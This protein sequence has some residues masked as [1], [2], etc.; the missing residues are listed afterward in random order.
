MEREIIKKEVEN[1]LTFEEFY[2]A[3]FRGDKP[4]DETLLLLKELYGDIENQDTPIK[5]KI[6]KANRLSFVLLIKGI[7]GLLDIK[8]KVGEWD[9]E[10]DELRFTDEETGYECLIMRGIAGQLNGYVVIPKDHP[11]YG[12]DLLN[13]EE[14]NDE[15]EV[16]GGVTYSNFRENEFLIGFDT[17]HCFDFMPYTELYRYIFSIDDSDDRYKNMEYIKNECKKLAHQLFMK[18]IEDKDDG[19]D[20]GNNKDELMKERK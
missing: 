13:N 11:Y 10:P 9:R 6:Y 8:N 12:I 16:H 15:L 1:F 14:L 20:D 5:Y 7:K 2:T 17:G 18:N 3:F 4:D 19:N